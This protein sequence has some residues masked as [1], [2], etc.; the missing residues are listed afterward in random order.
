MHAQHIPNPPHTPAQR[1][2]ITGGIGS[3]KS[4]VA[5]I[6]REYGAHTIDADAIAHSLSAPNG[7][8]IPA[9]TAAFGTHMV[10]ADGALNRQAMRDL[11]FAEPSAKARLEA[12]LHPLIQ[13]QC[14]AQAAAHKGA[15]LLFDIPLLAEAG[16]RWRPFF[17]RI[18]VVD[19]DPETQIVRTMARSA[20]SRPAVQNI[21]HSQAQRGARLR[22]ADVVLN[23]DGDLAALRAQIAALRQL[24]PLSAAT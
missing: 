20:L 4:T 17:Q 2:G 1:W 16:P 3:G 23:N 21:M 5:A 13:Q 19:C 9:I 8:A 12:I 7:A 22:C 6:L 24:L 11:V 14:L 15:W 18:I 10:Q